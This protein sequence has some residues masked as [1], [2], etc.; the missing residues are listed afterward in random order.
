[1]I[2]TRSRLLLGALIAAAGC[3]AGGTTSNNNGNNGGYP[4]MQPSGNPV[5]VASV[6]VDDDFFSPN[7]VLLSAGGT[8]TWN[9]VGINGHSVT[10]SG[11]PSFSPNAPVSPVN[12]TLGPVVFAT[13]G[14]YNY[15]CTVHGVG[16]YGSTGDMKGTIFVR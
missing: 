3:G 13:A 16:G 6:N 2:T 5:L 15:F 14:T 11:A 9:W 7:A 12:T 4:P 1:V 10:S 8:V